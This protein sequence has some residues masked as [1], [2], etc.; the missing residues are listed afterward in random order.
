MSGLLGSEFYRCVRIV[1]LDDF[2]GDSHEHPSSSKTK[3]LQHWN[4]QMSAL[5]EGFVN[6][7]LETRQ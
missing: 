2:C 7:I 5:K 4:I 1:Q 6:Y 3:F